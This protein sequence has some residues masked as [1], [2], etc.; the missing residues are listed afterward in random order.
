VGDEWTRGGSMRRLLLVLALAFGFLTLGPL[1]LAATPAHAAGEC[2]AGSF[3]SLTN[4]LRASQGLPA[5]EVDGGLVGKAQ[6]W[7]RTMANAGSIFHSNLPDGISA[8]WHRLGE[9]VGMGPDV[10]SIHQALVNSPGHY[11]NLVDPG[12]RYV[13]V[14]V[15]NANG[16]CYVSEAFMELASQPAP[17]TSAPAAG[18]PSSD[19]SPA[20]AAAHSQS[21]A[22]A[23]AES[24]PPPPP[25]PPPPARLTV[26]LERLRDLAG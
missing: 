24:P 15:V 17:S 26:V 18:T 10:G 21:A 1:T 25:P 23:R 11:A 9:N 19:D 3:V 20:P 16:T 14:G 6:G 4:S 13:G 8:D 2:D 12:F 7:A 22:A 5:Y